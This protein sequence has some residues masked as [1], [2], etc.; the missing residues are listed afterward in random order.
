MVFSTNIF[1]FIFLPACLLIYFSV[2]SILKSVKVNNIVLLFMSL[3]F[4]FWGNG[5][6]VFLLIFSIIVNYFFCR[7][8]SHAPDGKLRK[9]VLVLGIVINLGLL[10]YYKYFGFLCVTLTDAFAVSLPPSAFNTASLPVGISFYTF[11]AVSYLVE[12]YRS[13]QQAEGII[14]FGTYL[15]LFPHLV[16]GPIVRHSEISA[17]I[18][19][20]KV[21]ATIF[22]EGVWRFSLGLGK[23]VI[24]ADNLGI[25][26]DQ[27]FGL[28]QSQLTTSLAWLGVLC[29]T[30]QIYYDFS[31]Y[32]DMAIGLARFFGFHFPENFNQPY[33]AQTVTEF[34]R[35]WH[36]TLTRWFRD[37]LYIP[38]GGNRKGRARTYLNLFIVFFLCGFW[39][40]AAWTYVVWGMYHGMLL[41]VERIFSEQADF[42]MKGIPSQVASFLLV[43]VGWVFFRSSSINDAFLYIGKMA[44]FSG[45]AAMSV[46]PILTFGHY[47][48]RGAVTYLLLA[49]LFAFTPFEKI[50]MLSEDSACS[51]MA[52][53]SVS[54]IVLVLSLLYLSVGSYNP[55]IYFRF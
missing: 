30:F 6:L 15:S 53:G 45:R 19:N 10:A 16:A 28:P 23:K 40:G 34:W 31:G 26:S 22:F 54:V 24:L 4:Y 20:R 32:T 35:R 29:Y 37:F 8:I 47:F 12:T 25:V 33:R 55:F 43:A 17:E 42:R 5:K 11:M 41:V 18:R 50:K 14:S 36:M 1:L 48:D 39:H 49:S 3:L 9:T 21:D 7:L 52:R 44:G 13:Q 38:L 46:Q 2:N 51:A 27:I